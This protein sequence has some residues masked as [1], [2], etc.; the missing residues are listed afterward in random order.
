MRL[1]LIIILIISINCSSFGQNIPIFKQDFQTEFEQ[2]SSKD[3][4]S[5][6]IVLDIFQDKVGYLWFATENGLNRYDGYQFLVYKN[7]PND[8]TSLSSN[9][10]TCIEEDIYGNLWIGTNY[11]L[12]KYNRKTNRFEHYFKQ[13]SG[14]GISNNYIRAIHADSK[15]H[16]WIETVEGVLNKL[17][18]SSGTFEHFRHDPLYQHY[19]YYHALF[20][21]NDSI[22]WIGGRNI[23]PHRFNINQKSFEKFRPNP[24][25]P[26]K[27]RDNDVACFFEDS[28]KNFYVSGLDGVYLFDKKS[29]FKKILSTSTFTILEDKKNNIWFGTGNGIYRKNTND[30]VFFHYT[31]N[32]NNHSSLGGN[33]VRK[34]FQDRSGV[35]WA[36]TNSGLS[37]HSP[38]RK[39]FLHYYHIPGEANTVTSNHITDVVEDK[40]GIIWLATAN[41]GID[42]FDRKNN[43]FKNYNTKSKKFG[44]ISSNKVASLYIDKENTLYAGLWAGVGFNRFDRKTETFE[45]FTIRPENTH[46]DWYNDFL[47]S[48]NNNLYLGVWGDYGIYTFDRKKKLIETT[49]KDLELI[50]NQKP[51]SKVFID[52]DFKIWL[53]SPNFEPFY[54]DYSNQKYFYYRHF[55]GDLKYNFSLAQKFENNGII[56]S[57]IPKFEKLYGVISDRNKTLWMATSNGLIYKPQESTEFLYFVASDHQ[58]L[59]GHFSTIAYDSIYNTLWT[60]SE[61]ALY[62]IN[63]KDNTVKKFHWK[64]AQNPSNYIRNLH[65]TNDSSE[66]LLATSGSA[67]RFSEKNGFLKIKSTIN[68]V[69]ICLDKNNLV[70][71]VSQDSVFIFT[72]NYLLLNRTSF[73]G[74][75]KITA[76]ASTPKKTIIAAEN[77]I[78]FAKIEKNMMVFEKIDFKNYINTKFDNVSIHSIK[79]YKNN[80][81]LFLG[82]NKGLFY[83]TPYNNTLL[84]YRPNEKDFT[85]RAIHLTSCLLEDSFGNIWVGTTN[86]GL[87]KLPRG[88]NQVVQYFYNPL[89][90]LSYWGDNVNAIFEDSK[91]RLWIAGEGLN[92]YNASNNTFSHITTTDGLPSNNIKSIVEDDNRNLWLGTETGLCKFNPDLN[93]FFNYFESDEIHTDGFTK[94]GLKLSNGDLLFGSKKG[95]I[96]FHPDSLKQ[97]LLIPP[98]VLTRIKIFENEIFEDLSETPHLILKANQNTLTF[99]FSALDYNRPKDNKYAYK[100]EGFD[101]DWLETNSENRS[102]RYTR[103]PSGK[104]T[105]M[106]K[107][108]NNDGIWGALSTPV[109]ITIKA[110]FWRKWWFILLVIVFIL[111]TLAFFAYSRM[112]DILKDKKTRELEHRLLRSQM[113]PHFIFNSLGAIQSFIFKNKPM[114][115]GTYLSNFSELVRLILENSRHEY[116]LLSKEIKTLEYYLQLQK[117]RFPEKLNF[118]F[119]IDQNLDIEE[120]SIPPMMLQPFIENS[121]EHGFRK[122]Q[123]PGNITIRIKKGVDNIILETEDDGIGILTAEKEKSNTKNIYQSL[124]TKITEERIQNMNKGRKQ[125]I[126]LNIIDLSTLGSGLKGTKVSISIPNKFINSEKNFKL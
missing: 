49:G 94:A 46:T 19:Y 25:D 114:V 10:V 23:M 44:S 82:T 24:H 35:I 53:T 43:L 8:T 96:I 111:S 117:L 121:I 30:S 98:V 14:K 61:K 42:K 57:I 110:P 74:E 9:L 67:E 113:N 7:K 62:Q 29:V 87:N 36:A 123:D 115:A 119:D 78:F 107:G 83:Y 41:T 116:I 63:V 34:L 73:P 1:P 37:K 13:K 32:P 70:W 54:L 97:N 100:L 106:L 88:S 122:A 72:E 20:Q 65:I 125:K 16:L 28:R 91:N 55:T 81:I 93:D 99:E 112:K 105:F 12:N 39:S 4:L 69:D 84:I 59:K 92:L 126:S 22:L 71:L 86:T 6:N 11:G 75:K 18:I 109:S 101:T 85:G 118:Y 47:E 17:H 38:I 76:I 108:S 60:S 21:E 103:L 120:L 50:P 56:P 79:S 27:K 26:T 77:E 104:Y 48:K 15:G 66:V 102:I 5:S 31:N 58:V 51:I 64:D 95:F 45:L 40:D 33:Y 80:E 68:P 52:N 3:G 90:T 124:A 2:I 89:D